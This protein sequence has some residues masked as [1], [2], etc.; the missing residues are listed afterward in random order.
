MLL[1][2][3]AVAL[4]CLLYV[5]VDRYGGGDRV[6]WGAGAAA[7]LVAVHADQ[8]SH[9][10]HVRMYGL[11]AALA[12]LTAWLMLRAL[13]SE[14]RA[15]AWWGAYAASAAALCYT[16]Y[17]GAFTVAAQLLFA[18]L[19]LAQRWRA[20]GV[21]PR[22]AFGLLGAGL[23]VAAL[24]APWLSVLRRQAARV[25]ADY[26]IREA[27]SFDVAGAL[28]RWMTGLEWTPPR[29]AL[30]I[31]IFAAAALWAL[32]RGDQGQ[33]F[34]ALQAALPWAGALGLSWVAGR[35]LFLE[36]YLF[37]S[38]LAL[39]VLLARAWAGLGP[40]PRRVTA[41]VAGSL[42]TLGLAEEIGA[43][44]VAAPSAQEGARL[45]ARSVAPEDL[46]LANAPRDLNVVL[47]YL[48]REGAAGIELKCPASRSVGHLS[49]VSSIASDEIVGDESV[50][51]GP[52]PRVWRVRLHSPRKWRPEPAPAGWN[53]VFTR[54]FEGPAQTRLILTADQR[55][56]VRHSGRAA[57]P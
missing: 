19:A 26:W 1:G 12:G 27:G 39:L 38:Q 17:Y 24:F 13:R 41:A 49:Q 8:V 40:W 57:P 36:R 55:V 43:R 32:W 25:S 3:A 30:T 37:F 31:A 47:Y 20:S 56:T 14:R 29:P 10:R 28:V 7:L 33:R 48:R 4:A 34:L 46:V 35:T 23:L 9:S 5:E 50:W 22:E 45:L 18:S 53:L 51:D 54:V 21:G 44:P 52:W 16:H 11:G 2:L 15:L 42:I 6:P